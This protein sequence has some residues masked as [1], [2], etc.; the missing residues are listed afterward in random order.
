MTAISHGPTTSGSTLSYRS[1]SRWSCSCCIGY[2]NNS[3]RE[4][5]QDRTLR[6]KMLQ[7]TLTRLWNKSTWRKIV[8]EDLTPKDPR[9]SHSSIIELMDFLRAMDSTV[10]EAP[11]TFQAFVMISDCPIS[12][13]MKMIVLF[14]LYSCCLSD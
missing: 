2:G 3:G 8:P 10:F 6:M 13:L 5:E 14:C 4:R 9:I 7:R 12:I 11:I 1:V